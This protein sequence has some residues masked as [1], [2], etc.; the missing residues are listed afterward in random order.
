MS[1]G[2][3]VAFTLWIGAAVHDATP[4][5]RR[6]IQ[7]QCRPLIERAR[8][9]SGN[10]EEWALVAKSIMMTVNHIMGPKWPGP[11]GEWLEQIERMVKGDILYRA[12]RKE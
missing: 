12:E 7:T 6:L 10:A 3:Y 11:Q 8:E 1:L 4:D 5:Q 9:V 2:G